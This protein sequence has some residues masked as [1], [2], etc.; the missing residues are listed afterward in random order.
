MSLVEKINNAN[1][2]GRGNL[3]EKGV[4]V[5]ETATTYEIMSKIADVSGGGGVEPLDHTVTFTVDGEPYEIVS[6]INGNS[7]NAPATEP[8]SENGTFVEWQLNGEKVTFPYFLENDVEFNAM[9]QNVRNEIE[10][11]TAGA[12]VCTVFGTKTNNE[13]AI[14]GYYKTSTLAIPILIGKTSE[15][16]KTSS[17]RS[18]STIAYNGETWYYQYVNWQI[19]KENEI[20]DGVVQ[21]YFIGSGSSV[22][23]HSAM[24]KKLL[25]YYFIIN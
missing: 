10:I 5:D 2:L 4:I 20:K 12:L 22:S 1:A 9:F 17:T 25:D 8:T 18:Q 14:Y 11:K 16:I 3:A 13:T 7:V 23:E 15:S 19:A 21:P 6:V 24:A